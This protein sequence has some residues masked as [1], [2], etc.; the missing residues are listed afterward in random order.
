M[1]DPRSLKDLATPA[2]LVD[3]DRMATNLETTTQY[4]RQWGI[5]YR[6]HAKTHK[7]A[8]LAREQLKGGAIGLTVAT[9]EEA[10]VMARVADDLLLAYPFF[11][12]DKLEQIFSLRE[13]VRLTFALDSPRA[14]QALATAAC[15][16]DRAVGV[17]VEV[18]VG[19]GRV[20]LQTLDGTLELAVRAAETAGVAYRGILF[21]PGHVRM[22]ASEQGGALEALSERLGLIRQGLG[23]AGLEPEVV[24]GGSTPTLFRSHQLRGMTE[25]RSGTGIFNDRTTAL[26]GACA[27]TDCAYTILA[28]VV[29]TS[30]PGQVVVDAGSKALAKEEVNGSF[31]D[32]SVARGFGCVLDRPELRI[33]GLSEEHGIIELGDSDW[34]PRLGDLVRIVPNHVCV[35]VNLN[36]R[37]W[38]I[39]GQQVLGYWTVEARR[40]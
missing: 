26:L 21:Y 35:S 19:L 2:A 10:T 13:E 38:Q 14:L 39:Q 27:W 1:A 23:A 32:S 31:V 24:S 22:P 8:E 25:V 30:I 3:V 36:H 29:S 20:G 34:R 18:D 28:T 4:C 16:R 15:R 12:P 5:G 37:L 33:S 7:S 9:L 17:L 6:P 11:A 40:G